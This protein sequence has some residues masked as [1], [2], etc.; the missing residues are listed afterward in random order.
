[1]KFDVSLGSLLV[2]CIGMISGWVAWWIGR[3]Q[4]LIQKAVL[5]AEKAVNE[6]RDFD[7]LIR[8][9]S[10][11]SKNI[12]YGFKDIEEQMADQNNE[13]REIK[14]WLIRGKVSE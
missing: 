10:E 3:R 11:I 5:A 8:N 1:M 12:A 6:K 13:L 14:A 4:Q 2:A 7:H 9:Q